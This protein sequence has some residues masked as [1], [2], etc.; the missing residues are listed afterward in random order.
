MQL[1]EVARIDQVRSKIN[2][3]GWSLR[4]LPVKSGGVN[5]VRISKWKLIA[6]RG[7][8]SIQAEN[9]DLHAAMMQMAKT[10]NIRVEA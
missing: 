3:M 4:E 7:D 2:Q 10:L 9:T 6:Y 1:D 8:K 5:N